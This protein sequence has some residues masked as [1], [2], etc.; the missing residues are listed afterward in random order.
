M[1]YSGDIA[2]FTEF[3]RQLVG[4]WEND[5]F[6]PAHRGGPDTPYSYNIM[7]LPQDSA[8][9]GYI[10]KNFRYH[11]TITFHGDDPD[12]AVAA[13]AK[14][15]NRGGSITQN[16][17]AIFYD[18]QVRF[19]DP[20]AH[21]GQV[22]HVENG[23]WLAM[24]KVQQEDGPYP[25]GPEIPVGPGQQQPGDVR[26]AKQ[27]AVPHGNAILALGSYE[28]AG[29]SAVIEGHPV[30]PD[31]DPPYPRGH[32]GDA[33][34]AHADLAEVSVLPYSAHS[35]Q[36]NPYPDFTLQPNAPLQAGLGNIRARHYMHWSVTTFPRV[37]GRGAV[38]NI[39]FEERRADVSAYH[40]DYW[41]LSNSTSRRTGKA[42]FNYL[43]YTQT[44]FM[45]MYVTV[46]GRVQRFSFPHVTCN[47][48][49]RR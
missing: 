46:N 48:L 39:P 4:T 10:L 23:A 15:P 29:G 36:T 40:A 32:V 11:E 5:D 7:P 37:D 1:P 18:Q 3:Q 45:D 17:R 24:S 8:P 35:P 33:A 9:E 27:I 30:I 25:P 14:A 26:I 28:V 21:R 31:A 20:A 47:V 49:R 44:M 41:L 6:G 42:L 34:C 16:A 22:V 19:T 43:A 2:D 13:A 38:T 12:R